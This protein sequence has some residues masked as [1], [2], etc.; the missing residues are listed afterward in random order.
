MFCT[1]WVYEFVCL[2]TNLQESKFFIQVVEATIKQ[3]WDSKAKRTDLIDML[4]D[5]LKGNLDL[6]EENAHANDQDAK[7]VGHVKRTK[8]INYE[9][10]ISTAM[11]TYFRI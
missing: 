3:R 1:T 7:L 10:V 8:Q 9:H 5:A 2:A 6:T 11:I 4:I